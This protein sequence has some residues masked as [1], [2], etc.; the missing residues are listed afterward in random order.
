MVNTVKEITG[1]VE[2]LNDAIKYAD[3]EI[4]I[5]D[6]SLDDSGF[7]KTL[8]SFLERDEIIVQRKVK[9]KMRTINIRPFINTI[10]HARN[11]LHITTASIDRRTVRIN[12]ILENLFADDTR[13]IAGVHRKSQIVNINGRKLTPLDIV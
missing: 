1:S 12:E 11:T 10:Y 9:G 2:S 5:P 4:Q 13:Y 6:R 8:R 3:Y 7:D